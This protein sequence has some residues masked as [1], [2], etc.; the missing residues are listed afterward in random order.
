M[1]NWVSNTVEVTGEETDLLRMRKQLQT[2]HPVRVTRYDPRTY[3]WTEHEITSDSLFSFWNISAP[4]DLAAYYE[5]PSD[6]DK[7]MSHRDLR[8]RSNY[9]YYWN[10]REWGTK[11]LAVNPVCSPV[12]VNAAGESVIAYELRTAWASPL[13]ALAKLSGQFPSLCF[14]VRWEEEQGFGARVNIAGAVI[15][16]YGQWDS[17]SCEPAHT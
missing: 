6:E 8:E 14:D 7:E 11:W 2:P 17:P 4:K 15:R 3:S 16:E 5:Q 10:V 13:P 12:R 1:P 9:W